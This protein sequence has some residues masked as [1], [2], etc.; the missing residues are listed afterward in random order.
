MPTKDLII[1]TL[2][3]GILF[4]VPLIY[5]IYSAY[6]SISSL[7][8][9]LYNNELIEI[10]AKQSFNLFLMFSY[11]YFIYIILLIL[12][13][14]LYHQKCFKLLIIINSIIL[15]F[16]FLNILKTTS[17]DLLIYIVSSLSGLILALKLN[18]QKTSS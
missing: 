2:I 1:K 7:A 15:I 14:I 8:A 9:S 10:A 4:L 3:L 5:F 18:H 11:E 17:Y 6:V 13:Y 12:N 16:I